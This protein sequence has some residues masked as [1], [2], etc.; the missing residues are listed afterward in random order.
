MSVES[1]AGINR[2]GATFFRIPLRDIK[3]T[4]LCYLAAHGGIFL[5]LNAVYWDDWTVWNSTPAAVLNEFRQLGS[6]FNFHGYVHVTMLSLGPWAYRLLTFI[7]MYGTGLLFYKILEFQVWIRSE[8]RLL[9]VTLFLIFPFNAARVALID[10]PYT[11]CLFLFFLGWYF[12]GKNRIAS[13]ACFAV[14]FC[15]ESLLV[16]YVLPMLDYY[17]R[18]NRSKR[19]SALI[20]W[21]V[22][23]ADFVVVPFAWFVLKH[24]FFKPFGIHQGYNEAFGGRSPLRA[25]VW[26]A[27]DFL[28]VS[29]PVFLLLVAIIAAVIGTRRFGVNVHAL[30]ARVMRNRYLLIGVSALVAGLVPYWVVGKVPGFSDWNSRHQILMPLGAAFLFLG[31]L[32]C[33]EER[34]KTVLL[35]TCVGVFLTLNWSNYTSLFF[36]WRKQ[37]SIVD[38]LRHSKDVASANLLVFEDKTPNA[39]SRVYRFY[40]WNGLTKFAYA[41]RSDMFSVSSDELDQYLRGDYDQ[42]FIANYNAENHRRGGE[43]MVTVIIKGDIFKQTFDAVIPAGRSANP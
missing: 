30:A 35:A 13:L 41:G 23:K 2:A 34:S 18:E 16:F 33:T 11:L 31:C 42:F 19:P 5:I 7:L 14:S 6:P 8:D 21:A 15:M 25:L 37:R 38:F 39:L 1:S 27:A 10:F 40:E 12:I 29:T 20:V 36:D 28:S 22:R 43:K 26:E 32:A 4:F 9:L 24:R 17:L 3:I